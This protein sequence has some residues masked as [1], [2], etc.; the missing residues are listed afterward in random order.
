[1]TV[2]VVG[3]IRDLILQL[4]KSSIYSTKPVQIKNCDRY[5]DFPRPYPHFALSATRSVPQLSPPPYPPSRIVK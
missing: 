5:Y 2:C 1:G 4:S 3:K